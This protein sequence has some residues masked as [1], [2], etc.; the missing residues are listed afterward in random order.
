MAPAVAKF[1]GSHPERMVGSGGCSVWRGRG[2]VAKCGPG[3]NREAYV[4][5]GAVGALPLT[6]PELVAADDGWVVMRDV[7]ATTSSGS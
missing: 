2:F 3:A 7:A 5:S 1:V 4:L 6:V